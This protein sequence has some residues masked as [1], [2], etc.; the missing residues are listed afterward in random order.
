[1]IRVMV[2]CVTTGTCVTVLVRG[3]SSSDELGFGGAEVVKLLKAELLKV[4]GGGGGGEVDVGGPSMELEPVEVG[5]SIEVGLP[6][7]PRE[8][9]SVEDWEGLLSGFGSC[10][11]L[12]GLG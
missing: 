8:S 11:F 7:P 1:M 3:G 9:L 5:G 4:V 12:K 6:P 2:V 10:R